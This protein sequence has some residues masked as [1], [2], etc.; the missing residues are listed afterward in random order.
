MTSPAAQD[1]ELRLYASCFGCG[2]KLSVDATRYDYAL[3]WC[4]TTAPDG[5]SLFWCRRCGGELLKDDS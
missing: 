5:T 4:E 2:R 1:D 3:A